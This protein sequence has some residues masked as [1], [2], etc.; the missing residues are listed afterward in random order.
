MSEETLFQSDVALVI[1]VCD[2]G[3]AVVR[4]LTPVTAVTPVMAELALV[5]EYHDTS[6]F[7]LPFP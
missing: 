2:P 3:V 6:R 4:G 5:R 1:V 7:P